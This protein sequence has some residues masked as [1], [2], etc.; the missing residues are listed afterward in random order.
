MPEARPP[1]FVIFDW[2]GVFS[3]KPPGASRRAF[4]RSL[5]LEPGTLGGF[6]REDSWVQVSTGRQNEVDFWAGVCAGFPTPPGPDAAARLWNHL[7]LH[8][9]VRRSV[10]EMAKR[11]RGHVSVSLLS[12]AAPSLREVIAPLLPIF[13]DVVISAEVGLRKPDPEIFHLAL[14]R[15][16]AQPE[17]V[18]FVDDFQHNI[19]A[20][21]ALGIRGHRFLTPARLGLA[22]ERHGLLQATRMFA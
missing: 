18:L 20:A 7:F 21:A 12:N 17:E 5:G 6:F 14:E 13:A 1:R 9:L 4:E 22:L 10:V 2:G 19:A 3:L 11:L 8:G 16:G 15:L